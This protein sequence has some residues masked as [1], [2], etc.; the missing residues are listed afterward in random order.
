MLALRMRQNEVE[1]YF[2]SYP[3]EDLLRKT[4]F[5]TR[6][7]GDR[8]QVV[9][10]KRRKEPDDVERF[11]RA[12]EGSAQAF[13]RELNRRK[14]RQIRDFYRNVQGQPADAHPLDNESARRPAKN[15]IPCATAVSAVRETRAF[16]NVGT[17]DATVAHLNRIRKE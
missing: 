10:G 2:V 1:F 17:A 16:P 4:R 5:V 7:Y 14:V 13:Q 6:F 8:G 15:M 11:V 12:I 3:A 9:G